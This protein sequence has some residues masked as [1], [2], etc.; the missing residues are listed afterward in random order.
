VFFLFVENG[1]ILEKVIVFIWC[2]IVFPAV[3]L[4]IISRFSFCGS[5]RPESGVTDIR[6]EPTRL[7]SCKFETLAEF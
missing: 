3:P 7:L 4:A 5:C 1:L 6:R 2:D